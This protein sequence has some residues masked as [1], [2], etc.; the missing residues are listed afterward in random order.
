MSAI[1]EPV[2]IALPTPPSPRSRVTRLLQVAPFVA[3]FGVIY[4][5]PVAGMLARSVLDPTPG[6]EN[7]LHIADTPLYFHTFE[8]TLGVSL[9]VAISSVVL[10]FPI[11]FALTY[12]GGWSRRLLFAAVV[13]PFWI[14]V[15]VRTYAW[16]VVLT[17]SGPVYSILRALGINAPDILYSP[18]AVWLGMLHI[19]APYAILVMYSVMR[20]FDRSLLRSASSLGASPRRVLTSVYLPLVSSGTVA[21][22]LLV[23]VMALGFFITPALLGG[24]KVVMLAN[25][26]DL[27]AERLLDFGLAGALSATL[28]VVILVIMLIG[29]SRVGLDEVAGPRR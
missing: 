23:F 26:I 25:L 18:A 13:T 29:R 12:Y 5:I 8:V 27:L 21:A 24:G 28:L 19:L 17:Q 2:G 3:L 20:D 15:L 10:G 16:I 9:A 7:Y 1:P 6:F 14:S 4:A 22:F 11:A